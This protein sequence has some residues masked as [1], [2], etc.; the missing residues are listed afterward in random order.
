MD[1]QQEAKSISATLEKKSRS[2]LG[3]KRASQKKNASANRIKVTL[4]HGLMGCKP[5]HRATVRVLGLRHRE[6]SVE[7]LDTPENRGMINQVRYLLK[8]E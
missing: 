3:H 8:V 6:H 4:I 5:A 2:S 7:V 1:K